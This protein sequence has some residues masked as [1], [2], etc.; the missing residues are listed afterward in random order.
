MRDLIRWKPRQLRRGR[1]FGSLFDWDPFENLF[2][3]FHS[4]FEDAVTYQDDD[5]N[6]VVELEVPGF[7]KDNLSVELAG[8]N[9]T[10]RGTREV[11]TECYVGRKEI[12]KSYRVG[13]FQDATAQVVDGILRVTIKTP[14][15]E[16]K[17]VEVE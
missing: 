16:T 7:N 13:D 2:S 17:K 15:E 9:L 5:K 4:L 3:D 10:I 8:G 12:N 1:D 11:K 14:T 6:I